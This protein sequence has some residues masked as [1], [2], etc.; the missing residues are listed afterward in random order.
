MPSTKVV[1]V[2]LLATTGLTLA[3]PVEPAGTTS[4]V[5][6]REAQNSADNTEPVTQYAT[7]KREEATQ[8]DKRNLGFSP[9]SQYDTGH[10]DCSIM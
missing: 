3:A 8:E 10:S 2:L 1:P 5:A 4:A 9:T 6:A 7:D